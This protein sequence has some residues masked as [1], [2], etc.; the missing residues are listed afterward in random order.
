MQ[1]PNTVY[2]QHGALVKFV[3]PV[4]NDD[5]LFC[6]GE[7]ALFTIHG[8]EEY[9]SPCQAC[10]GTGKDDPELFLIMNGKLVPPVEEAPL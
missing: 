8:D 10:Y 4:K 1:N 9:T 6:H 3:P 5:C 7:G 2:V